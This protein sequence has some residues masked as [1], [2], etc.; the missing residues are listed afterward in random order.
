MDSVHF[1]FTSCLMVKNM[2]SDMFLL[3]YIVLATGSVKVGYLLIDLF[4]HVWSTCSTW[5]GHR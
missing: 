2:H 4:F 5:S 1:I 3:C